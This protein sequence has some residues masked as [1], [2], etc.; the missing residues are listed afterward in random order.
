MT[1]SP[2]LMRRFPA[3]QRLMLRRP[4]RRVPVV[5]Q[6]AS[7]DCAAAALS[8]VLRHFGKHVPLDELRSVLATGRDGASAASI[9]AAARSHGL[10]GRGVRL[11]IGDLG[12]LPKASILFWEFSHFVVFE[13][14]SSKR[15][16]VVD[17]ASG[18][19]SVPMEVF[20]RAFTGVALVL[21]PG[22]TFVKTAAAPTKVGGLLKQVVERRD[23]LLQILMTSGLVQLLSAA[24]PLF[25]GALID[26]VVPRGDYSLLLMLAAAYGFLQVFNVVIGFVRA[27]LFIHLRTQ[28]EARFTLRF[29]DHLVELPYSFFQ[30]HTSGDLMVRLGSNNAIR[31]ILTST[32]LSTIMDGTMA[33][34]YLILM[35]FANGSLALVVLGLALT[36]LI[37]LA[38]IRWRQRQFLAESLENQARSQTSQ[39]EMLSGMETLK[40]MGLEQQAAENWT[41][42]FVDGLNISIRRSQLDALFGVFLG[43]LGT[44]HTLAIMFGGVLLVLHGTLSLGTMMAFSALAGGFMAPL[45]NLV[46]SALQLQMLEIYVERLNEVMDTPP[47]QDN[48]TVA[49]VG[50]LTGV[51]SLEHVTFRYTSAA[52]TVVDD[53][54]LEIA[55]GSRIALVGRT[56]SGKSTLARLLAGLYK[57]NAGRILFDGRDL[58]TLDRRSVRRQLGIVT[59]DTQLFGGSIRRNIALTDADMSLERVVRAAKIACIH[60]EIVAM[61]M[62][63][64]TLLTD[65]GLSLSGGQRQRLAIA[66]A[67]AG[68]PRIL[69]LDEATSHL[70]SLTEERVNANLATLRCTRIVIAHRLSTIRDADVILVLDMGRVVEAGTH[71]DLAALGGRY[72]EFLGAQRG[73][74]PTST[75]GTA[76]PG[77]QST[78][79]NA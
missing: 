44:L 77:R 7:T 43:V 35:V 48:D 8:M 38:I 1:E 11:D 12:V 13:R 17:P 50:P 27:Q 32:L 21:E 10:R 19:R 45:N 78:L 46:S 70:D 65:R 40:A 33:G 39:M 18:Y 20:R 63:Y 36:R 66:R 30:R 69:V 29:F 71:A 25:T 4:S 24:M 23:L 59:Q 76:D 42:V 64:E 57:P 16:H 51:V 61:P 5:R 72:A 37:A 47:E 53:V 2:D 62:G 79:D 41:N 3:L 68:R 14:A 55:A 56:G 22:E 49:V 67:L 73:P 75:S 9:L 34:I 31:E 28:L 74:G 54:S 26:R 15:V 52:P 60:D 58:S 6:L